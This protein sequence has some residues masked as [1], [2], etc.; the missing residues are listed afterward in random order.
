MVS[1]S[2]CVR[3]PACLSACPSVR[4]SVARNISETSEA[5][6]ITFDK[7]TEA[8]ITMHHPS[9]SWTVSEVIQASARTHRSDSRLSLHMR[10]NVERHPANVSLCTSLM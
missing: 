9:F 7:V 4:L 1:S 6:A 5:N 3:A 10:F 8:V 2:V